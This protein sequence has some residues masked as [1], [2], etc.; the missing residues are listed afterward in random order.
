MAAIQLTR[1]MEPKE[2]RRLGRRE[3]SGRV[4]SR[5]FAIANVLEGMNRTEAATHAGM[6]RQC[7]RDWV[8]RFNA[9]GVEGLHDRP[10]S[11]TRLSLSSGAIIELRQTP[12]TTTAEPNEQGQQ[13]LPHSGQAPGRTS[14]FF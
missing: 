11:N 3:A 14:S 8:H 1:P 5:M 13:L 7:L 12:G 4:A 2:L 9:E 10:H 6:E